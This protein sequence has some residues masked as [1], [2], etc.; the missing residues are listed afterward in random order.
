MK[1]QAGRSGLEQP[2][3]AVVDAREVADL[4]RVAAQQREVMALV[5]AAQAAQAVGRVLIVQARD[6]RV[7][8]IGGHRHQAP[9]FS[10]WAACLSR[11]GWGFAGWISKWRAMGLS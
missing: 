4:G 10:H 9:S 11:R 6:H 1:V 8:G 2:V 7:A 5:Q 3:L